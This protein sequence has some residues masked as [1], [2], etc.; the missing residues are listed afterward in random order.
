MTQGRL[1]QQLDTVFLASPTTSDQR[2]PAICD[3]STG[4][5]YLVA[6]TGVTGKATKVEATLEAMVARIRK[7]SS[8][9]VAVGFGI[10][11]AQAVAKVWE[12]ADGAVVGSAI[13]QFMQDHL[14]KPDLPD[15]VGGFV[16]DELLP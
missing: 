8:L 15:L 3:A 13:V 1:F 7:W 6:R 4:F 5:V 2:I 12:Y 11:S 16:K 10:R 14:E 9:P